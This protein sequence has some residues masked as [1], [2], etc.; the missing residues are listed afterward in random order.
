M[1][2]LIAIVAVAALFS[3]TP[4]LANRGDGQHLDKKIEKMK[5]KLTL[6]D[7]QASQVRAIFEAK[8]A[9]MQ[10]LMDE[11]TAEVKAV[12]TPE[13]AVKYDEMK[14]EWKEKKNGHKNKDEAP[15]TE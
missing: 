7:E 6:T 13:Q 1:K 10:A 3:A 8:H 5:E 11:A 14:K 2:K 9:K 12:L 15:K 4:A